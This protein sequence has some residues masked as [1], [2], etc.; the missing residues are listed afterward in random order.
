MSARVRVVLEAFDELCDLVDRPD[1]RWFAIL[2]GYNRFPAAPLFA[3]DRAEFT[4][5]IRPVIPDRDAM[6][7]EVGNV[8]AAL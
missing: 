8:G 3:I 7:L 6:F 2:T 1:G 4:V 5:F